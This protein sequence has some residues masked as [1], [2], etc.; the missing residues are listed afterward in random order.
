MQIAQLA[1]DVDDFPQGVATMVGERGVTL[2][3]GQKQRAALARAIA[4]DPA[5]LILDDAMSSVDTHTEAEILGRLRNVMQG[6]TTIVISHR[7]STVKNL[8]HIVVLDEGR[9]VEEGN[10]ETL[11]QERGL[12]AE[13]YRRQLIGEELE[14]SDNGNL[15]PGR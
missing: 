7:C 11:L 1:K 5:I 4:K 13:M 15:F 3:G 6:R 9:I 2:S 12:Y 8:D 14:E 10:H